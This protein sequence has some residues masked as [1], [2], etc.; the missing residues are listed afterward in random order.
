MSQSTLCMT[1]NAPSCCIEQGSRRR[2]GCKKKQRMSNCENRANG[3]NTLFSCLC[4]AH[5]S[6]KQHSKHSKLGTELNLKRCC[7]ITIWCAS[8]HGAHCCDLLDGLVNE[9]LCWRLAPVPYCS[10][11]ASAPSHKQ[12][13][14][15]PVLEPALSY[16]VHQ[17]VVI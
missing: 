11:D 5:P 15:Q 7:C 8:E 2:G 17:C 10:C 1:R 12:M 6:A 13:V 9:C 4:G 16:G 3:H 14:V